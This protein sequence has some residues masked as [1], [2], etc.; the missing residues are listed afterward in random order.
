MKK[1]RF[2]LRTT[3]VIYTL[4]MIFALFLYDRTI[5]SDSL[6]QYIQ[7]HCNLVP[8]AT[9]GEYIY[10][11]KTEH[12]E[13]QYV[14]LQIAQN[15]LLMLPL[16]ILMPL[17]FD[18]FKSFKTTAL[19]VIPCFFVIEI[20]QLFFKVGSFDIDDILLYFCGTILGYTLYKLI[21]KYTV[22]RQIKA[23]V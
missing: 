5:A 15:I 16:G 11:L 10:L 13:I 3:I 17:C 23:T 19:T 8:F 21:S 2:V 4:F 1:S 6:I 20:C 14:L 22:R 7:R 12:L 18:K 9:F